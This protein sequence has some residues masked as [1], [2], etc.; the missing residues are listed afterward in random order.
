MNTK[1]D[2]ATPL[3]DQDPSITTALPGPRAAEMIASRREFLSPSLIHVFP[4]MVQRASGCMVEDVD[5]NVFLDCEA[6]IATASTGHCHPKVVEAVKAQSEVL[7]HMCG[8]D[9]HYPGYGELCRRLAQYAPGP[10]D[11]RTYL[12]NSGTE[13]VEAAIKL[14]RHHTGRSD[15]IAFRGAFHGRSLGSLSLTA[16]KTKYRRR[17]GPLLPGVHHVTYANPSQRNH[18]AQQTPEAYGIAC[19]EEGIERDLFQYTVPPDQ[20]AAIVVEP[21]QGEG[22]YIVPPRSFLERLRRLCDEHGILLVFDEVQAGMGRTGTFF[23]AEHFGVMP[24]IITLA[25]GLATGFPLGA[26]MA[27]PDVMTWP[28][29][30]HGSTCAGNPVCIAAALATLDLLESELCQNSREVGTYLQDKLRQEVGGLSTVVEVRGL[31]LMIGI[32]MTSPELAEEILQRCYRRGLLILDCGEQALRMA[33][34]LILT[35]HQADIAVDIFA[36]VC[37]ECSA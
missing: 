32:E 21:V 9:F 18:A 5:G 15:I 35:R 31:G 23:A 14:A 19:V 10:D 16:S 8:T 12:S 29:G 33:P 37:R 17:F 27:R 13:S 3:A 1:L 30:T 11:W 4:L 2:D 36:A 25:K 24:D 6:G 20:V 34:P 22:G 28:G 26:M 7:I